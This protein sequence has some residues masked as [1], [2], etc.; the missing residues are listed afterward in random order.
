MWGFIYIWSPES[1]STSGLPKFVYCDVYNLEA[2]CVTANK[3]ELRFALEP[4]DGKEKLCWSIGTQIFESEV[5]KSYYTM[6]KRRPAAAIAKKPAAQKKKDENDDED[7]EKDEEEIPEEDQEEGQEQED[8]EEEEECEEEKEDECQDEDE[9]MCK[10]N[11]E[12]EEEGEEECLEE[13]EEQCKEEDEEECKEQDDEEEENNEK[14]I[15]EKEAKSKDEGKRMMR[16]RTTQKRP[17]SAM[18]DDWYVKQIYLT[19]AITGNVRAYL[20][21]K[22]DEQKSQLVQVAPSESKK[23][24]QLAEKLKA[25]CEERKAN[26]TFRALKE[27]AKRR[28][29]ELLR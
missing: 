9:E 23:Y 22:G 8:E 28:K 18:L 24:V 21:A 7:D 14:E 29:S 2:V 1:G 17:F 4:R 26:Y 12:C 15:S 13:E 10:E 27:W 11:E 6:V 5:P 16:R 19:H 3:K 25:E 20:L